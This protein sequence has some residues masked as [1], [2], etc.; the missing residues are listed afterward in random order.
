MINFLNNNPLILVTGFGRS[1]T[2]WLGK[3][4]DSHPGIFYRNEPESEIALEGIPKLVSKQGDENVR[5]I[6]LDYLPKLALM[7]SANVTGTMP[8][9]PEES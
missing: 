7:R 3:I 8:S 6:V 9:V 5:K 4:F 2:T 1:G